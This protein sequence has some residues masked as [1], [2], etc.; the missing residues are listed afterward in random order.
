MGPSR[1]RA[2]LLVGIDGRG[3]SAP[4]IIASDAASFIREPINTA[5]KSTE[6]IPNCAASPNSKG[7]GAEQGRNRE[8]PHTIQMMAV[9][10]LS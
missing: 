5:D 1:V 3:P 9:T 10:A 2:S 8:C 7:S 4:P 6:K